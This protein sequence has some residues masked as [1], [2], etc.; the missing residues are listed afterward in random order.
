MVQTVETSTKPTQD[1]SVFQ[2]LKLSAPLP[3]PFIPVVEDVE[4]TAVQETSDEEL[5]SFDIHHTRADS[6]ASEALDF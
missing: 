6:Q 4:E 1:T 2:F 5:P 3:K